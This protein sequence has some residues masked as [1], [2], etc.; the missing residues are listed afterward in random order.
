[1]EDIVEQRLAIRD[2]ELLL[3]DGPGFGV[4]VDLARV[5]RFDRAR[6]GLGATHVDFGQR[7]TT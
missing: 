6:Q 3:P 7:A 4:E 1:M 2:F 5:G